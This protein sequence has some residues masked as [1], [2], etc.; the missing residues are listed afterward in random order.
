M[1]VFDPTT[2]ALLD[3]I[4]A[5]M[6]QLGPFSAST[7]EDYQPRTVYNSQAYT[8]LWNQQGAAAPEIH[9]NPDG[10]FSVLQATAVR[11]ADG[12]DYNI[13][14]TY[15]AQGNLLSSTPT[16]VDA[17]TNW[18]DRTGNVVERITPLVLAGMIG[19]GALGLGTA[20]AG[21]GAAGGS[22]AALIAGGTG[23]GVFGAGAGAAAAGA[24]TGV[25]GTGAAAAGT[26]AAAAGAA[27]AGTGAAAAGLGGVTAGQLLTAGGAL[28]GA[29]GQA[30]AA[31]RTA[32]AMTQAAEQAQFIPYSVRGTFGSGTIDPA[33]RTATYTA[34]PEIQAATQAALGIGTSSLEQ[35]RQ[36]VTAE[37]VFRDQTFATADQRAEWLRSN[38]DSV[39]AQA[40]AA[41]QAQQALAQPGR[42]LT[43]G[44]TVAKQAGG[45]TLGLQTNEFTAG[46]NGAVNPVLAAL[47]AGYATSDRQSYDAAVTTAQQ[48]LDA[49][50]SRGYNAING[51]GGIDQLAAGTLPQ[52]AD[53][54][55]TIAG[56]NAGANS[57]LFQAAQAQ[58]QSDTA[59]TNG[60]AQLLRTLG[61][62]SATPTTTAP[63]GTTTAPAP[64]NP[65]I[66]VP[67]YT[68]AGYSIF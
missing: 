39:T 8:N 14:G 46:G 15:D 18:L 5:S 26:G 2:Q 66:S 22:E 42:D 32:D 54:S 9:R 40:L 34:S 13:I 33:T 67:S 49:L 57:A 35:A 27:G 63:A 68:P 25:A 56:T 1:A 45:G 58:G 59:V 52:G 62:P 48:R 29:A 12:L 38:P 6:G 60:I 53:L 41:F 37:Q 16:Q 21:V 7:L 47:A 30:S 10:T 20:G 11:G 31:N 28:V 61:Q 24:G 4:S 36:G 51:A 64:Y 19:A 3:Q 17:S 50:L 23:A 43:L 55:R 44:N 65:G